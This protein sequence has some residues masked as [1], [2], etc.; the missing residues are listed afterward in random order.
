M[1]QE[2]V[3]YLQPGLTKGQVRELLGPPMGKNPFRPNHW[4]YIFY[5][6]NTTVHPNDQQYIVINFDQDEMLKDWQ[7]QPA[8]VAL[9]KEDSWLGLGW[10]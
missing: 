4:E 6:S 3:S 1:T 7:S 8:N 5:S 9:K 2:S 10:F